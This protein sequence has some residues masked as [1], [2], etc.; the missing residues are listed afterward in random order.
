MIKFFPKTVAV[1]LALLLVNAVSGSMTALSQTLIGT[2]WMP[3][4]PVHTIAKKGDIVYVGGEFN[5]VGRYMPNGA[6]LDGHSGAV[7]YN[8]P[9]PDGEV[10]SVQSDGNGGFFIAGKFSHVGG[11][12]RNGLAHINADGTVGLF[13]PTLTSD[14]KRVVA[15]NSK[16]VIVASSKDTFNK[17]IYCVNHSGNLVWSTSANGNI[18]DAVLQNNTL[19]VAGGFSK[20]GGITRK[21]VAALDADAGNVMSWNIGD[22]IPVGASNS[23]IWLAASNSELF[24]TYLLYTRKTIS[25]SL[26]TGQLNSW[27]TTSIR[28]NMLVHNGKIYAE[29]SGGGIIIVDVNTKEALTLDAGPFQHVDFRIVAS[30]NTIYMVR[31]AFFTS[32]DVNDVIAFDETTK[33]WLPFKTRIL[34]DGDR[35][36]TKYVSAI[37]A[38][39]GSVFVGGRFAAIGVEA[40]NR[41]YSYNSATSELTSFAP[42]LDQSPES[43]LATS[44]KLY[45]SGFFEHVNNQDRFGLASFDIATGSLND[46]NPKLD[47]SPDPM[48]TQLSGGDER[49]Y[50]CGPFSLVDDLPRPGIAAFEASSG[51]LLDWSPA[52]IEASVVAATNDAIV[53]LDAYA[54]P[55]SAIESN[56]IFFFNRTTGAQVLQ[57]ITVLFDLTSTGYIYDMVIAN[58]KLFISGNFTYLKRGSTLIPRR[59]FAAI[60]LL[61]GDVNDWMPDVLEYSNQ[62]KLSHNNG[63]VYAAGNF[64]KASGQVRK[65]LAAFDEVSGHATNWYPVASYGNPYALHMDAV[66]AANDGIYFGGLFDYVENDIASNFAVVTHDNS[67]LIAGRVF[68][69]SNGNGVMD[70]TEVGASNILME[71]QPGNLFYPT[72]NNGNYKAYVGIGNYTLSLVKPTYTTHVSPLQKDFSFNSGL[73]VNEGNDFALNVQ[74]GVNDINVVLSNA[75]A[76]R[77]GF[78]VKY[79]IAYNN[80]GTTSSN[81][82]V[83]LNLDS[84][85][86]FLESVP[87]PASVSGNRLQWNYSSLGPTETRSIQLRLKLPAD[88]SLLGRGLISTASVVTNNDANTEDNESQ[89]TQVVTGSYDPN[90]KLVTPTGYGPDGFVPKNIPSLQYTIRFQNKGTDLAFNIQVR[91]QLDP[92]LDV[93]TFTMVSSSHPYTYTITDGQVVWQFNDIMLPYESVDE[94]GSHGFITYRISPINDHLPEGTIIQNNANIYFDFNPPVPTNTVVNTIKNPPY[95]PIE[96]SV[97]NALGEKDTEVVVPITVKSFNNILA[98]QFSLA[99]DPSVATFKQVELLSPFISSG[100]FGVTQVGSGKLMFAWADG[101]LAP[102]TLPDDAVLFAV[103]LDLS[104]NYGASTSF[105][106]SGSPTEIEIVDKDQN[107]VPNHTQS[108]VIEILS[109]VK[110]IGKILYSNDEAIQNVTVNVAGSATSSTTTIADGSYQMDINASSPADSYDITPFKND[111][112]P[113]NGIDVADVVAIQRHILQTQIFTSA[114]QT[115]AADVNESRS[116]SVQDITLIKALILGMSTSYPANTFWKFVPSDHTFNSVS[117]PFPFPQSKS[118]TAAQVQNTHADFKGIKLGDVN[119]TRDNSQ[120][121]RVGGGEI[122]F[123]IRREMKV[124]DGTIEIPIRVMKFDNISGYQFTVKWDKDKLELLN[125]DNQSVNSSFGT[126]QESNGWLSVLWH[127][128][129]GASTTLSDNSKLFMLNFRSTNGGGFRD[130]NI[131][132]DLTAARVY[133]GNLQ[134]V[135]YKVSWSELAMEDYDEKT[136]MYPNPFSESLTVEFYSPENELVKL[137]FTDVLGRKVY[138]GAI[139][140]SV[141]MNKVQCDPS[142]GSGVYIANLL[143]TR[144]QFKMKIVKGE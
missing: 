3:N 45:T 94:P 65:Y 66:L 60:D 44:T 139:N 79:D 9:A 109:T 99:W 97:N 7:N 106:I 40:R 138:Q 18:I 130:I 39:G 85:F 37:A 29:N 100:D 96:I 64:T 126:N 57:P 118:L 28:D 104:G 92:S 41:L 8:T 30:G 89:L 88:V 140:A 34:R 70:G 67:N 71:V 49:I 62:V 24:I 132:N 82:T 111:P 144:G 86:E 46:W 113:L 90:D 2:T 119:M 21:K 76:A 128:E 69:D 22:A 52:G 74:E 16:Y 17:N 135:T 58:G 31:T 105:S 116:V 120:S 131:T 68:L 43:L 91:D 115:I 134:P 11:L 56:K 55:P 20:V 121:A 63:I 84:H 81:G 103:R 6:L 102:R 95:I 87:A 59:G 26:T 124:G 4:G 13:N 122:T 19:Y 10:T 133:N 48:L 12:S 35:E 142:I 78:N 42:Q 136:K 123:D 83:S 125:L 36:R 73:E 51:N 129:E 141:G 143:S 127:N 80:K 72:D 5:A 108:G 27:S 110:L 61:T 101:G 137:E 54:G 98:T 38:G 114:F 107:I 50:L 33:E 75:T 47:S 112:S 93:S 15:V 14:Y 32:D 117:N 53:A 23:A 77:P 1:A 25:V